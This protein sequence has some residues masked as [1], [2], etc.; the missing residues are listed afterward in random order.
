MILFYLAVFPLWALIEAIGSSKLSGFWRV[1][2]AAEVFFLWTLGAFIY[3]VLASRSRTLKRAAW[4]ILLVPIFLIVGFLI[5]PKNYQYQ[6]FTQWS[7]SGRQEDIRMT[8]S[9]PH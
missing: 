6:R 4:G 3:A 8:F 2:W 5:L 1:A 9:T 7:R